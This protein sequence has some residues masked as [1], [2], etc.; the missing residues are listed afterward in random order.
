MDKKLLN[1]LSTSLC[2]FKVHNKLIP[3]L[4]KIISKTG[5]E[6]RFFKLLLKR[7]KF[8][9]EFGQTA[10][11]HH[12]EF[13]PL[14]S[15]IYSMHLSARDFNI[16]ILYTFLSDETILLLGFFKRSGKKNTDY[17]SMIPEALRRKHEMEE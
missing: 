3:E 7:L 2:D 9:Q 4:L 17:Q 16:R 6:D 1:E 5:A 14:D 10:Q 12:E 13:E 8:L 15:E 11:E